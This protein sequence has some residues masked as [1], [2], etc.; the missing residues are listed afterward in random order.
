MTPRVQVKRMCLALPE[1]TEERAGRHAAY[2]DT[3]PI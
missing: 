1:A 3:A 2:L